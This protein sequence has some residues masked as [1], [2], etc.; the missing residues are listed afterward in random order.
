MA[1]DIV[2]KSKAFGGFDKEQVMDFVNTILGEK[3]ALEKSVAE[4]NIKVAEANAKMNEYKA[5]ADEAEELKNQLDNANAIIESNKEM[6]NSKD[7][8]NKNLTAKVEELSE[9]TVGDDVLG[10]LEALRAENARLKIE[11]EKKRDL[12]RQVGAA[13]LDAR[14]HSESLVEEAKAKADAVTKAVYSAIGDTA[15]KIDELSGGIGEI[16]RSFQKSVD[17][18]ELRI[19]ALTGDMSKSAQLL[20]SESTAVTGGFGESPKVEY[21]FTP[22][23]DITD[24]E[25][26]S[27][28]PDDYDV[29]PSID[30]SGDDYAE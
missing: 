5:K 22:K 20:I 7:E 1:N 24:D 27:V 10:E 13:M 18:V 17:E 28:N 4:S 8:E 14:V 6:L 2:F 9:K 25:P 11:N 12:E 3:K 16:A 21:D 29:S 19:K 15:L 30:L 23:T 26:V